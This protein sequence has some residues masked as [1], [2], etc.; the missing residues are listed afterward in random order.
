MLS[1]NYGWNGPWQEYSTA[2]WFLTKAMTS[3]S[4]LLDCIISFL[5]YI[6]RNIE[7]LILPPHL[8]YASAVW[9]AHLP[10][11]HA[12]RLPEPTK[13][14]C[15]RYMRAP[16]LFFFSV[17]VWFKISKIFV[18]RVYCLC[19]YLQAYVVTISHLDTWFTLVLL[20]INILTLFQ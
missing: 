17:K 4:N 1:P 18:I 2:D 10:I 5:G 13:K 11:A 20:T 9:G 16:H 3:Y 14:Y 12:L 6:N 15:I 19:S 7:L 8:K